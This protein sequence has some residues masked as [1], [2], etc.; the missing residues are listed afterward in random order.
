MIPNPYFYQPDSHPAH[1]DAHELFQYYNFA[2]F[3]G[4]LQNCVVRWTT[5]M[6]LCAGTCKYE[7]FGSSTISLS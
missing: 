6:T 4:L 1:Y 3:N 5:K 7:G 2:L